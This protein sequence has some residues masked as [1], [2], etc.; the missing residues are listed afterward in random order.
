LAGKIIDLLLEPV[1]NT[2]LLYESG[3]H[4]LMADWLY[5]VASREVGEDLWKRFLA[6]FVRACRANDSAQGDAIA[7]LAQGLEAVKMVAVGTTTGKILEPIPHSA[8]YLTSELG[9]SGGRDQLEPAL[10][11]LVEQLQA[12]TERLGEPFRVI[13]DD[14]GVIR[15]WTEDLIAWADPAIEP[16]SIETNAATFSLPLQSSEIELATSDGT[17]LIQLADL[18]AGAGAWW[19]RDEL[20][21]GGDSFAGEIRETGLRAEWS[22]GS[23]GFQRAAL[24][25]ED[26]VEL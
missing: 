26:L 21:R 17:P 15:R 7:E 18:V 11:S 13:H 14:S 8:D 2:A 23:F 9:S 12:W 6:A 4:Q 3:M 16:I 24:L 1:V 22:T 19:L 5:G 25:G 20:S 10:T